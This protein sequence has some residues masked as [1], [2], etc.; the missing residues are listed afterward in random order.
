MSTKHPAFLT[1]PSPCQA[2]AAR[3]EALATVDDQA[4]RLF[5]A[6]RELSDTRTA[7]GRAR[8]E[9]AAL[10]VQLAARRPPSRGGQRELVLHTNWAS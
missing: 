7:L 1:S 9:A 8:E 10:R 4:F 5:Q 3:G 2:V 6:D